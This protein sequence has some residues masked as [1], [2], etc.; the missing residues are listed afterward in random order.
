[1]KKKCFQFIFILCLV[2]ATSLWANSLYSRLGVGLVHMRD[3][4]RAI[5][6]GNT[7]LALADGLS[8]YHLNPA[9]LASIQVTRLQTEFGYESADVKVNSASGRFRDANFNGLSLLLPVKKGYSVALGFE[10]Y[11]RVAFTLNQFGANDNGNYEEIYSGTG[12]LDEAYLAFAGTLGRSDG[13]SGLRYGVAA[14]FYFGRIQR[15][16]RVNFSN[17]NS[18]STEDKL[19]AYFRGVGFHAG[20]QW[21]HPRWQLGLAM[22]PPI[23]LNVETQVEYIFGGES[24]IIKTKATLPL[25]V[26]IGVGYRP[27]SKLQLAADFRMQRWSDVD[28]D[29]RVGAALTNSQDFGAGC[30][31][32]PSRNP[33]DG[34]LK[35]IAYRAGAAFRRLPYQDPVGENISE[36]VVTTGLGF[37]FRRGSSRIDMA[38]EYGKRGDQKNNPAE[39]SIF[40]FSISVSGAERWFVRGKR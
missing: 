24:E 32:I 35:R 21:F 28:A 39:E 30:E 40:G 36:W 11:S 37:P 31:W 6:M 12:G 9:A 20:V 15:N 27:N 25:W 7:S 5:G 4:V 1:M 19:G 8:V 26:G 10:P 34:Y 16:W 3:G 2:A 38:F 33:I 17:V 14:D 23:D 22:R 18:V 29:K 13:S